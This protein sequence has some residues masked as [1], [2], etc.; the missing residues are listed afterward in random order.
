MASPRPQDPERSAPHSATAPLPIKDPPRTL[1]SPASYYRNGLYYWMNRRRHRAAHRPLPIPCASRRRSGP[2]GSEQRGLSARH[3]AAVSRRALR[4]L[5]R[6]QSS[7]DEPTSIIARTAHRMVTQGMRAR[8]APLSPASCALA[9]AGSSPRV[10]KGCPCAARRAVPLRSTRWR[11]RYCSPGRGACDEMVVGRSTPRSRPG[12]SAG[13]ARGRLL[14]SDTALLDAPTSLLA[15]GRLAASERCGIP[16]GRCWRCSSPCVTR[17]ASTGA[18]RCIRRGGARPA[19]RTPPSSRACGPARREAR[20]RCR[21]VGQRR[22]CPVAEHVNRAATAL[23]FRPTSM[24]CA[25]GGPR[26]GARHLLFAGD[27]LLP[28]P[29]AWCPVRRR[30]ARLPVISGYRHRRPIRQRTPPT[31][32]GRR[33]RRSV[34]RTLEHVAVD[35]ATTTRPEPPS[36][37]GWCAD[38]TRR[39]TSARRR[40]RCAGGGARALELV[41]ARTSRCCLKHIAHSTESAMIATLAAILA[42]ETAD[43]CSGL[44]SSSLRAHHRRS[45]LTEQPDARP[46]LARAQPPQCASSADVST[47]LVSGNRRRSAR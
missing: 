43:G 11:W 12:A 27:A 41:I 3:R 25:G 15:V 21:R 33:A 24:R 31:H 14:A 7:A 29:M 30:R 42:A 6:G 22:N 4:R 2:L 20:R 10:R 9:A 46:G 44:P 17:I 19:A 32:H 38:P 45:S 36:R 23:Q 16:R 8:A 40:R 18:S 5:P 1:A 28:C 35:V 37:R 34:Q 26:A 47:M 39:G 13:P